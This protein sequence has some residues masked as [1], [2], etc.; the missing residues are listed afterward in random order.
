MLYIVVFDSAVGT[1]QQADL[2]CESPFAKT[3][4]TT[5]TICLI[6]HF[7]L[8]TIA[9]VG[10]HNNKETQDAMKKGEIDPEMK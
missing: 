6:S 5:S 7:L 1:M 9:M 3:S 8:S 10:A 2:P 4:C